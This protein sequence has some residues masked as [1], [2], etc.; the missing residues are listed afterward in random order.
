M[1]NFPRCT[2]QNRTILQYAHDYTALTQFTHLPA[3]RYVFGDPVSKRNVT[4]ILMCFLLT[5]IGTNTRKVGP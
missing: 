5:I 4:L 1:L 2:Q 3:L